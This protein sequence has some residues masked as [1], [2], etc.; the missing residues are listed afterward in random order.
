M[1][2]I[3]KMIVFLYQGNKISMQYSGGRARLQIA[4]FTFCGAMLVWIFPILSILRNN[5]N[6]IS[7]DFYLPGGRGTLLLI[8]LGMYFVLNLFTWKLKEVDAYL[9]NEE[10]EQEIKNAKRSLLYL[11]IVGFLFFLVVAK[12]NEGKW[13]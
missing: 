6:L 3:N 4:K 12:Y 8:V 13:V 11:I 7:S 1:N 5:L 10:N 9:D 2:K